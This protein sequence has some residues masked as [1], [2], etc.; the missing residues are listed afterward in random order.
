MKK[1]IPTLISMIFVITACNNQSESTCFKT[2][3]DSLAFAKLVMEKYPDTLPKEEMKIW[4]SQENKIAAAGPISWATVEAY[5]ASHDSSPLFRIGG[6]TVK[7]LMV[8]A[9]GLNYVRGLSAA[10]YSK[11]Y[12]R[13]GKKPDGSYTVIILPVKTN[14]EIEKI[15]NRN[16]DH[17]D[18]CPTSCPTNFQ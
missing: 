12:L 6:Q 9:T 2:R 16:Y 4:V 5:S 10:N 15:D 7:G 17:L 3:E 14:G 13:F 18:P 11:L 8:D 1:L